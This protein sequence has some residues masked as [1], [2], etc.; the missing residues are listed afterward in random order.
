MSKLKKVRMKYVEHRTY[1]SER[2]IELSNE[3][4]ER[5]IVSS[6]IQDK[7]KFEEAINIGGGELSS[8]DLS[9]VSNSFNIDL[10]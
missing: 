6:A 10:V 1:V 2:I 7:L 3:D 5:L 9:E 8:Q 4:Y